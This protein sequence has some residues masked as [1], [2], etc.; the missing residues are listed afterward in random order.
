MAKTTYTVPSL[1][2]ASPIY[3]SLLAKR[4]ELEQRQRD[5][6]AER[7]TLEKQIA[8]SHAPAVRPEIAALL[9]DDPIDD[10]SAWRKRF[11]EL[12][13]ED[14]DIEAALGVLRGRI[15]EEASRASRAVCAT[16]KPEYARRVAAVCRA[17]ETLAAARA[18]YEDLRGQFEAEDVAWTSLVPMSL[19]FLGDPR[20]GH[21]PRLLRDA[22]EAGYVG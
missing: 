13:G 15:A 2:D 10:V 18:G 9:G 17:V 1:A 19:G 22:K 6:A 21:L 5:N 20:D 4:A 7:R 3:A 11:R 12:R 8:T 16:V 14:A